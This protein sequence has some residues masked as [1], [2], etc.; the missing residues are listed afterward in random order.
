MPKPAFGLNI[1]LGGIRWFGLDEKETI[2]KLFSLPITRV[3]IPIPFNEVNP[4]KNTWDFSKRD[5]LI[6]EAVKHNLTI[7]LQMGIKTIG[8]PEVNAPNWLATQFPYL[9]TKGIQID[10]DPELQQYILTYLQK[11]SERYLKNKAIKTIQVENEPFSKHLSVTNY[12]YISKYFNAQEIA[13]VKKLDPYHR[14][15]VQN[16]PF[17]TPLAIPSVV[18]TAD[19]IGLNIYNQYYLPLPEILYWMSLQACTAIVK[20]L[21]KHV[22]V[23]EYQSAAWLDD[24]TP[25]IPFSTKKFEQGLIH[26]AQ[27]KPQAIFL[28]DVEQVLARGTEEHRAILE[29]LPV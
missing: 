24:N 12:R 3:R 29:D 16:I 1:H 20:M 21:G 8:W 26:I 17:D 9:N 7:D 5:F 22:F 25:A 14:P 10:K 4:Q 6:E 13:L 15:F 19:I 23:T 27:F 2:K 11:T 28:W 18:K